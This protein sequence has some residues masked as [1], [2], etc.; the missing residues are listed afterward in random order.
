MKHLVVQR[1]VRHLEQPLDLKYGIQLPVT[2][3]QE[4]QHLGVVIHLVMQLP[5][6]EVQLP[7]LGRIDGMRLPKQKEIL[8][9]MGVAGQKPLVLIEGVIPL[10][11]RQLL[12]QVK[13]NHVGMRHLQVRWVV[14]PLY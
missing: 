1:G 2:H 5:V 14:A 7:V 3:Q 10:V 9:D 11:K 8:Q 6:M 13:E 12:E 4:L